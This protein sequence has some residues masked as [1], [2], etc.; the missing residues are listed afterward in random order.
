MR[1]ISEETETSLPSSSTLN[2]L[3]SD[4]FPDIVSTNPSEDRQ[5]PDFKAKQPHD[6]DRD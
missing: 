4:E 3:S 6:P 2:S 5:C 1:V